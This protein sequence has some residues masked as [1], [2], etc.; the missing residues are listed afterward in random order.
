MDTKVVGKIVWQ[1]LLFFGI[2]QV[3]L[4]WNQNSST[5]AEM[6]K[7]RFARLERGKKRKK[8]KKKWLLN[9]NRKM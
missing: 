3:Q 5:L 2:C 1:H 4:S 7:G 6:R 8:G 9:R